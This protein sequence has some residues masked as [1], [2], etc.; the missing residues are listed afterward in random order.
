[1]KQASPEP[2]GMLVVISSPSGG[3]KTAVVQGLL[4][5]DPSTFVYSVTATTR[6]PRP[7]EREGVDYYFVRPE[8]FVR[9]RDGGELVEWAEVH[10][11]WYGTPRS[12]IEGPLRQGKVVLMAI[13]VQ[14]GQAV[15]RLYPDCSL[16]VF[17][18]PPSMRVLRERLM[19]RSTEGAEEIAKRLQRVAME[20][21]AARTYDHVVVNRELDRTVERVAKLIAAA[22]R[23]PA[24]QTARS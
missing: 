20:M 1:M 8:Q 7:G 19:K 21:S 17:I 18:K 6:P 23:A 12:S 2:R 22:R 16:L 5:R 9:M 15:R 3:G 4:R 10:G 14:G 13:D 24:R 11:Y